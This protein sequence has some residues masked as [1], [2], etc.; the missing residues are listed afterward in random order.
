MSVVSE[1]FY[2]TDR[3]KEV[4]KMRIQIVFNEKEM[5]GFQGMNKAA[6]ECMK[7]ANVKMDKSIEDQLAVVDK[8]FKADGE[9]REFNCDLDSR[10]VEI[11]FEGATAVI[12]RLGIWAYQ[13]YSMVKDMAAIDKH[14]DKV[15]NAYMESKNKQ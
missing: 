2:V 9:T 7:N 13:T 5:A 12:K 1:H 3:K 6:L 4:I 10:C 11:F 15:F 8:A 14:F